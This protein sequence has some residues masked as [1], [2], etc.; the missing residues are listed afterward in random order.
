MSKEKFMKL[1]ESAGIV[2]SAE[3]PAAIVRREKLPYLIPLDAPKG[4]VFA[5]TFCHSD[6]GCQGD[7]KSGKG[8]NWVEALDYLNGL[9]AQGF[10][11]CED[12]DCDMCHE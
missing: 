9:I 1:A 2:V 3:E 6:C 11:D 12:P 10:E 7:P 5:G 8:V 4:K